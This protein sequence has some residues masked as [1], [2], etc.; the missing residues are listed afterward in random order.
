MEVP[1]GEFRALA[2]KVDELGE[3]ITEQ[4]SLLI[5]TL[6]AYAGVGEPRPELFN[7]VEQL[8]RKRHLRVVRERE[9]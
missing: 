5:K 6:A 3:V 4:Q 7:A 1:T 2:A 9:R 8:P